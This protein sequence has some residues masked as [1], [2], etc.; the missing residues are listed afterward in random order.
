MSCPPATDLPDRRRLLLLALAGASL[1]LARAA[2]QQVKATKQAAQYQDTP[3][4]GHMCSQCQFYIAAGGQPGAGQPGAGQPGAGMMGGGMGSGKM[5]SGGTCKVVQ[6]A[7]SPMG[8]CQ[9]FA[10]HTG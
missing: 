9:F 10:P 7:I 1:P 2:A 4:D 6:G 5:M 8:W 3:K